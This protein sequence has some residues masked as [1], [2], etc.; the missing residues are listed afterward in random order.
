MQDFIWRDALEVRG[1]VYHA[2]CFYEATKD[3][4]SGI[5]LEATQRA[6]T[7]TPDSVLGKR[8]AGRLG[9]G[10]GDGVGDADADADEG[11]GKAVRVK[12]E[13]GGG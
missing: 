5:Q 8:K 9:E 6:R 7:A 1:R 10:G 3:R 2:S 13:E 11:W 12:V 4:E